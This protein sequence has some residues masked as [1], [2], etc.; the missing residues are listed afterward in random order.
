MLADS[1]EWGITRLEMVL[2][3]YMQHTPAGCDFHPAKEYP[4]RRLAIQ[5]A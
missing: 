2:V 5:L 1:D 4:F 3:G